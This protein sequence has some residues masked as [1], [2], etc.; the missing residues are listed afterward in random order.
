M[1]D[2]WHWFSLAPVPITTL[3]RVKRCGVRWPR[4]AATIIFGSYLGWAEVSVKVRSKWRPTANYLTTRA[5][6]DEQ[7][8]RKTGFL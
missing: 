6:M 3:P 7:R 1:V 2:P 5:E 8:A 4:H